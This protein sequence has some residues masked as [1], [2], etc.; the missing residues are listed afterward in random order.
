[1]L[2]ALSGLPGTGKTTIAR[3]LASQLPAVHVRIDTIEQALLRTGWAAPLGAEAY[4]V[5]HGIAADNLRRGHLVLADCV[6]A[7]QL[8]RDAWDH[9]AQTCGVR[10][11]HVGLV[12]GNAVEHRRR[13]LERTADIPGHELPTWAEV[14]ALRWDP[15]AA[16][17][18]WIDTSVCSAETAAQTIVRRVR[19]S[20][21][22]WPSKQAT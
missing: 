10:C 22:P 8:S 15:P 12:C 21:H 3:L 9:V 1:M 13:V 20:S 7:A 19:G 18:L 17:T 6:N 4:I 16:G 5:G 11:L 14:A 2:I